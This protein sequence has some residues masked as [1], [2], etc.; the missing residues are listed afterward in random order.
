LLLRVGTAF[1]LL[2]L[3]QTLTSIVESDALSTIEDGRKETL[4]SPA[5]VVTANEEL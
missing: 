4:V 5:K 1:K 3:A 2:S